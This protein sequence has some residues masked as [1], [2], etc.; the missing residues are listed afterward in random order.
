LGKLVPFRK[1]RGWLLGLLFVVVA[2]CGNP[3]PNLP[4]LAEQDVV[5]A[6]GDSLTHGTGAEVA[7]AYPAQLQQLIGRSVVNAGV[8]GETTAEGLQRLP[9]VLASHQPRLLL[10]CLG[11][12]DM[13]RRQDPAQT[14][15]NLRAMVR[16]A[17]EQGV[18]VVLIG[19]PEPGLFTGAPAFYA[20][21]AGEFGLPYEGEV[22]NEVLK[23]RALKSDPI[24]A[25]GKGYREVAERLAELLKKSGAI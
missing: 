5:L 16:L 22:F 11:G 3:G 23:D 14:A 9:E 6:F 24:H 10:L 13:L 18:A 17:Q 15:A 12:N 1:L 4:R 19:V 2:A 21:V 25:N 8:P 7:Q 20:D